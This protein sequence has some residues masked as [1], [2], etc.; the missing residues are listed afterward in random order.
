[1]AQKYQNL[2]SLSTFYVATADSCVGRELRLSS[3]SRWRGRVPF[4]IGL[5]NAELRQLLL[6]QAVWPCQ[7]QRKKDLVA[8]VF[9]LPK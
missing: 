7:T 9:N 6:A 8:Q 4:I 5:V 3:S 1:V 2:V